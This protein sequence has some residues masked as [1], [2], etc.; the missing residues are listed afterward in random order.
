M[1]VCVWLWLIEGESRATLTPSQ[2]FEIKDFL[3]RQ[4]SGDFAAGKSEA[5]ARDANKSGTSVHQ[6]RPSLSDTNLVTRG[7]S[8]VTGGGQSVVSVG[9]R[10]APAKSRRTVTG[11][12]GSKRAEKK[13][14]APAKNKSQQAAWK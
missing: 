9:G 1:C 6:C 8:V 2:V 4:R 3:E 11:D 14:A 10:L 12:G 5:P 7:H 13:S